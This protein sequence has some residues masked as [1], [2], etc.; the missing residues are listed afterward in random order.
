MLVGVSRRYHFTRV[1]LA[2]NKMNNNTHCWAGC[3]EKITFTLHMEI[4]IVTVLLVS[5]LG[6]FMTFHP[7]NSISEIE[8]PGGKNICR[9]LMLVALF[10]KG[11]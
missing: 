3:W 6:I 1:R 11:E 10:G 2:K 8:P 4:K 7:W 5:I 9:R